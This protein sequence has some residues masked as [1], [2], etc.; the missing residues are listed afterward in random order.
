M[1]LTEIPLLTDE[2]IDPKVVAFTGIIFLKPG[3]IETKF[4]LQSIDAL[5]E[6]VQEV[7]PPFIIVIHHSMLGIKIRYRQK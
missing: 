2:N 5:L 1:S 6:K 7:T 3:H 4:T